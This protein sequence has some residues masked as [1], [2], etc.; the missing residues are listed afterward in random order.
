MIFRWN[1]SNIFSLKFSN[2]CRIDDR[3]RSRTR[4]LGIDKMI[5]LS[6]LLISPA[7]LLELI[8]S[9]EIDSMIISNTGITCACLPIGCLAFTDRIPQCTLN[10]PFNDE[11]SQHDHIDFGTKKMHGSC[12]RAFHLFPDKGSPSSEPVIRLELKLE[13][14]TRFP[15]L[16]SVSLKAYSALWELLSL[17]FVRIIPI[18]SCRLV[19][20]CLIFLEIQE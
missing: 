6:I 12:T 8:H 1:I 9:N 10:E 4:W 13:F 17:N 7:I 14:L 18:F 20:N 19:L 16:A 2:V 15:T 5:V 11:S 3:N